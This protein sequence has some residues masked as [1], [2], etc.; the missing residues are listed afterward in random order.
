MLR[1]RVEPQFK[2]LLQNAVKEGKAESM[3]ELVRKAI[4]NYLSVKETEQ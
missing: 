3:S 2:E 1:L 4:L